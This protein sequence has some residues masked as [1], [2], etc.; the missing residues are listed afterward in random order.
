[1]DSDTLIRMELEPFDTED[2]HFLYVEMDGVITFENDDQTVIKA[3][4]LTFN[5]RDYGTPPPAPYSP[6]EQR[7][8]EGLIIREFDLSEPNAIPQELIDE[9]LEGL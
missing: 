5:E 8:T 9:I 3:D 2:D 7:E 1:M 6:E 4:D